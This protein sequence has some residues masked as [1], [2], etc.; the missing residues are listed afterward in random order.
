MENRLCKQIVKQVDVILQLK[1]RFKRLMNIFIEHKTLCD[2]RVYSLVANL[3]RDSVNQKSVLDYIELCNA[4]ISLEF[5]S[6]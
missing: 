2:K 3:P 6:V 5:L 1:V 4:R